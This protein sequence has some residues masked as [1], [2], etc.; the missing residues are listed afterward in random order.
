[1]DDRS[2]GDESSEWEG[3]NMPTDEGIL[4]VHA[5]EQLSAG[6]RLMRLAARFVVFAVAVR[7]QGGC[8][9]RTA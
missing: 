6:S 5:D 8:L 2:S 9:R 7:V 3:D 1:M 4:P